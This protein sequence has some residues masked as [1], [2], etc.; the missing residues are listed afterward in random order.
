MMRF[1]KHF[2]WRVLLLLILT[3][4]VA[5]GQSTP[6]PA[7]RAFVF[8]ATLNQQQEVVLQWDIAP[9]YYLY[10][11]KISFTPAKG[12][13]LL[14]LVTQ[15]PKGVP[16]S[17]TIRGTYQVYAHSL[18][19]PLALKGVPKGVLR[20]D[21]NYQG[22]SRAGFCYTPIRKILDVNL[23]EIKAP[24]LLDAYVRSAGEAESAPADNQAMRFLSGNRFIMVLGFLGL[25][26]LLSFTPCVLPMVPILSAII[27]GRQRRHEGEK[28][29]AF[30]LSLAYVTGMAGMYALAGVLVALAGR[31]VQTALQ[32]P[33]AVA[34][35]SGML[36]LLAMSLLGFYELRLPAR[37]QHQLGVLTGRQKGGTFIGVFLMG[38]LSTL[39]VSPCV[40]APLVA[41][42]GFIGQTGDVWLG[43]LTLTA[44]GIGMG[45]PLLLIGASAGRLLPRTGPWMIFLERVFGVVMLLMAV[46]M[47]SRALPGTMPAK[48]VQGAHSQLFTRVQSSAGLDEAL[49]QA[50]SDG[51]PVVLDFYADWCLPCL[52]MERS[53]FTKR[54]VQQALRP[55]VRLRVDLTDNPAYGQVLLRRFQQVGPPAV[56]FFDCNGRLQTALSLAGEAST[57]QLMTRIQQT[58]RM[59][60][61]QA[62]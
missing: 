61:C 22:C 41:V 59:P 39:I 28:S 23:S 36:V 17:D 53:V 1:M 33:L 24:A 2:I 5:G 19:V 45:I 57:T 29:R 54:T 55:F 58:E 31:N 12:D 9:G 25:G 30:L 44:L 46:W 38:A 16:H 21:I 7:D 49:K 27:V 8:S 10:R 32:Q 47:L 20:L 15:L 13:Q 50:H 52:R 43:V 26:L 60:A 56:I 37:W 3:G 42:L 14:P 35:F 11:D 34:F 48:G 6:L 40:S 4:P 18:R 62:L 51:K